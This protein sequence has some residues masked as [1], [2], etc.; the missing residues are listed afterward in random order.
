ML[1]VSSKLEEGYFLRLPTDL[2]ECWGIV[3]GMT[4]YVYVDKRS[5]KM[6][7]KNRQGSLPV[8]ILPDYG[9]LLPEFLTEAVRLQPGSEITLDVE[10]DVLTLN[11]GKLIALYLP[12]DRLLEQKLQHEID[13]YRAREYAPILS[14]QESIRMYLTLSR[15]SE[16]ELA[17]MLAQPDLLSDLAWQFLEDEAYNAFF[18]QKMSEFVAEYGAEK[19]TSE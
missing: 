16:E 5:M 18:E 11:R 6:T 8:R 12:N 1:K 2:C 4:L 7:K 15:W 9:V 14:L 10:N 13:D 17:A 19:E 3:E